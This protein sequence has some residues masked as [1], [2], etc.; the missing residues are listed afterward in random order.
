MNKSKL[1]NLESNVNPINLNACDGIGSTFSQ[2][3]GIKR[4]WEFSTFST[5]GP[6]NFENTFQNKH[7]T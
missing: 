4:T 5:N 6:F 1:S 3:V 7:A 2:H